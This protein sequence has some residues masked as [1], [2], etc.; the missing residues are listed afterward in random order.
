MCQQ[1]EQEVNR[2]MTRPPATIFRRAATLLLAICAIPPHQVAAQGRQTPP[3]GRMQSIEGEAMASSASGV[4]GVSVQEMSG[5]GDRWSGGSQLLWTGGSPGAVLDLTFDIAEPAVYAVELY[6]TRAPD[7]AQV[8]FS[9]D[10]QASRSLLDLYGPRVAPPVPY[11]A[12][13]FALAAGRHSLGLKIDGRHPQSSG[14]LV[15][16]DQIRL[17][18]TG[19]MTTDARASVNGNIRAVETAP[20]STARAGTPARSVQPGDRGASAAA[21]EGDSCASSCLGSVSTV[22]RQGASGQCLAWFRVPCDPYGCDD[23]SGM[24]RQSCANDTQCG[25]GAKCNTSTG[26]CTAAPPACIDASTVRLANGQTE[27]CSPYECRAGS[28]RETCES[29]NDCA[30]GFGCNS[31]GRCVKV[32]K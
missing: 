17:Y 12:G 8:A 4:R 27:S 2:A 15:G 24:C 23:T 7:Y 11:Q 9:I 30:S 16:L 3:A 19:A 21:G 22:H 28:C 6:F 26:M 18:P 32:L 13:T 29:S 5:F 25:Q 14:F 1:A 20:S 10:D 31:Y